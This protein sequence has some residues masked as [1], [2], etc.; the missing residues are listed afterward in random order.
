MMNWVPSLEE[1]AA[2]P[3]YAAAPV[4]GI[5][6]S[7]FDTLPDSITEPL[8]ERGFAVNRTATNINPSSEDFTNVNSVT[9]GVFATPITTDSKPG[10]LATL[11]NKWPTDM[12]IPD[13][14]VVIANG[15]DDEG[16][17]AIEASGYE[18]H[19]SGESYA[20]SLVK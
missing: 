3:G 11:V 6:T 18:L 16:L 4:V 15:V 19:T 2:D 20:A 12:P 5:Q 7:D 9:N 1:L 10:R 8:T 14:G 17:A 13:G